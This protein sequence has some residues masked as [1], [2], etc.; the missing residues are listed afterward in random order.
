MLWDFDGSEQSVVNAKRD[1]M[2]T[3][4][5]KLVLSKLFINYCDMCILCKIVP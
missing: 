5:S 4:I 3:S 2:V 1:L